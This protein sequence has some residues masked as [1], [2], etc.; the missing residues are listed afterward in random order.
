MLKIDAQTERFAFFVIKEIISFKS[1][2]SGVGERQAICKIL[3]PV[4]SFSPT[5]FFIS[6]LSKF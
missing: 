4:F 1:Y 5:K 2:I 6:S 3:P